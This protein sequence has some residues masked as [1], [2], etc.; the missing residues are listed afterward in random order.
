MP[1]SM[2]HSYFSQDVYKKLDKNYKNRIDLEYLKTFAQG[3]DPYFFYN[4]I[5]GPGN[6]SIKAFGDLM[7]EEKVNHFFIN[8]I[9][10]INENN[11]C[12]NKQVMSYLYGF[13][14]HHSLDSI[15]H[16]YIIYK[17]G[18]F[19]KKKKDSYKYN[20]LHQ[21][22]EYYID[23]YLIYNN[24]KVLP[25]D[26][27]IYKNICTIKYFNNDLVNLINTVSKKTYNFDNMSKVYLKCIKSMNLFY[28]LFNYDKYGIKKLCYKIIDKITPKSVDNTEVLSF[29]IKPKRYIEY[30][31][32][33]K[34]SWNHPTDKNSIS[35]ESFIELYIKAIN[36]ATNKINVINKMFDKN[37]IDNTIIKNLFKNK[38]YV[39]GEDCDI[40]KDIKYFE[41]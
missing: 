27:K 10:Y 25:K 28:R 31:N 30:L 19:D 11:L 40:K 23:A 22:I 36:D 17:S 33:S 4:L 7:H 5:I 38:S 24:E 39:T 6:K 9:N 1:S 3:P 37:K 15:A 2:T 29:Y 16:P 12:N 32:L 18:K 20:S 41:F 21:K 34:L 14:C 8:T 13:I 26:Y 35:N